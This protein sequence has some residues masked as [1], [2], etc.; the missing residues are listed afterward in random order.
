MRP[1]GTVGSEGMALVA[2]VFMFVI[3]LLVGM[4]LPRIPLLIIPRFQLMQSGLRPYPEPQPIDDHLMVQL[5]ML[6]RLWRLSYLFAL[7]PLT[8]GLLV[9]S[10]QPSTFGFGLFLGAGWA[11]LSRTIPESALTVPEG[12]YPLTLIH[13]IHTLRDS[14]DPCCADRSPTWEVEAVR[15]ANC[16]SVLFDAPRPGLGRPRTGFG[17]SSRLR[18]LLLDGHSMFESDSQD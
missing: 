13:T 6:R 1:S 2:A 5:M 18:L 4:L 7:L 15:C 17:F 10:V 16:R 12:P 3:A 14:D 9:L 8:L 11:L